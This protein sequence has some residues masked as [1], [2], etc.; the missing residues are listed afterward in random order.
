MQQ[1]LVTEKEAHMKTLQFEHEQKLVAKA[2][3]LAHAHNLSSM[4]PTA[5][6]SGRM[7][8]SRKIKK[9]VASGGTGSGVRSFLPTPMAV[10]TNQG[11]PA[12]IAIDGSASDEDEN[13][14]DARQGAGS[15]V[16]NKNGAS[17]LTK[18]NETNG[19]DQADSNNINLNDP[20]ADA[21]EPLQGIQHA[22]SN[23]GINNTSNDLDAS[24]EFAHIL[25]FR[26]QLLRFS[27]VSFVFF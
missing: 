27:R 26:F 18:H 21:T 9:K 24:F 4:A 3:E 15:P 5:S 17:V 19:S 12:T 14:D 13:F 8:T 23:G 20:N 2:L 11:T 1:A 25:E 7:K 16:P 10:A 6:V 22:E